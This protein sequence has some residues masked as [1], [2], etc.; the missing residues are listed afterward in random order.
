VDHLETLLRNE[1][2]HEAGLPAPAGRDEVRELIGHIRARRRR[3]AVATT[4]FVMMVVI[5]TAGVGAR[6]FA[7]SRAVDPGTRPT[8]SPTDST[9][10]AGTTWAGILGGAPV[11]PAS[12]DF[13]DASH[14]YLL[15]ARC[16]QTGS[17]F[18]QAGL[19][20]TADGGATW[21]PQDL[22]DQPLQLDTSQRPGYSAQVYALGPQTVVYD[23]PAANHTPYRRFVSTDSGQHWRDVAITPGPVTAGVPPGCR[24]GVFEMVGSGHSGPTVGCLTPD[25][26]ALPLA[27]PPAAATP[28]SRLSRATDGSLW[29][30][31]GNARHTSAGSGPDLWVSHDAG[32]TWQPAATPFAAPTDDE[33][34]N[35]ELLT[36]DGHTAYYLAVHPAGAN[37]TIRLYRSHN[38]GTSWSLIDTRGLA[39]SI[40]ESDLN[41]YAAGYPG[42]PAGLYTSAA[43][44]PD[45]GLVLTW[46][47]RAL[48]VTVDGP[49]IPVLE[50]PR[51]SVF[52]VGSAAIGVSARLPA[53]RTTS[54]FSLTHDGT[55]WTA[56][57]LP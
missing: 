12:G 42:G 26:T 14:G 31:T 51:L 36:A 1:F 5:V 20:V 10:P 8:A 39:P 52:N 22:P 50:V 53:P 57:T 29:V 47:G 54:A 37:S 27:N 41:V 25:G 45:G 49:V 32:R 21:T 17:H 56:M 44:L 24:P 48:R 13:A 11:A 18:C 3:R 6:H 23:Q 9:E 28:M 19:E 40:N 35:G 33:A 7:T 2:E 46:F 15:V 38:A 4:T 16:D 43:A 34:T 55:T 30:D